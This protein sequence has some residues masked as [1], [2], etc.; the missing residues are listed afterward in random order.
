MLIHLIN[1]II[2]DKSAFPG[3]DAANE[4]LIVEVT[5]LWFESD[6][7]IHSSKL[8]DAIEGDA[9]EKYWNQL[10]EINL[11]RIQKLMKEREDKK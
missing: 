5:S 2:K 11:P 4:D 10:A 3:D 9:R 1:L 8:K 7:Q 6:Q